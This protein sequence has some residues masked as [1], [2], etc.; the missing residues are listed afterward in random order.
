LAGHL[1][2]GKRAQRAAEKAFGMTL[3]PW[4]VG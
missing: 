1:G 2:R 3:E 4:N